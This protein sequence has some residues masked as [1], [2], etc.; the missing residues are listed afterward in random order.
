VDQ[1]V[2]RGQ[3]AEDPTDAGRGRGPDDAD[4]LDPSLRTVL[5]W[6]IQELAEARTA[7]QASP[8]PPSTPP[9]AGRPSPGIG[10]SGMPGRVEV[11]QLYVSY[12]KWCARGASSARGGEGPRLPDRAGRHDARGR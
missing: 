3:P 11:E 8:T 12:A 6:A 2:S 4:P 5:A 1:L 10:W 7:L 9:R